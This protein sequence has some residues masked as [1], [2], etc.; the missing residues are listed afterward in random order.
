M[1][2]R[3]ALAEVALKTKQ[4]GDIRDYRVLAWSRGGLDKDDFERLFVQL[5]V[6]TL[7]STSGSPV[8]Q[9]P[10]ITIGTYTKGGTTYLAVIEQH[11]TN[12][13][14]ARNRQVSALPCL[15][16]PYEHAVRS[17]VDF[18]SIYREL[19]RIAPDSNA[20]IV[21]IESSA[22]GDPDA[23]RVTDHVGDRAGATSEDGVRLAQASLAFGSP[24]SRQQ[25]L[26]RLIDEKL[27][28]RFAAVITALMLARPVALLLSGNLSSPQDRLDYLD[29]FAS[30][31]PYGARCGFS[32]S[33]WMQS[34][35]P[36]TNMRIG[37]SDAARREQFRI[38]WHPMPDAPFMESSQLQQQYQ[39]LLTLFNGESEA[40]AR[41]YFEVLLTLHR[42]AG[43]LG[44][45]Q[46]LAEQTTPVTYN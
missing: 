39:A 29:A 21:N 30:L 41:R 31:L 17:H 5:G 37:F 28:F 25:Q 27:G 8:E 38:E 9:P 24:E 26:A 11:R 32:A 12:M 19:Q 6:G 20:A 3:N 13:V 2:Q 4:P 33:T 1:Y 40:L 23:M 7:P 35:N 36:E 18:S 22:S 16:I 44:V 43:T 46:A 15:A 34:S 10:W 14:D 42:H 45:V